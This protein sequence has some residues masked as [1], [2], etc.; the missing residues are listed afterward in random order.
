MK[1]LIHLLALISTLVS[2]NCLD[3]DTDE[4]LFLSEFILKGD[5]STARNLSIV[6]HKEMDW[7]TSHAG[8]Y[9]FEMSIQ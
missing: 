1:K 4:P 3:R 5:Y 7:L 9:S 8:I 2:T 6:R